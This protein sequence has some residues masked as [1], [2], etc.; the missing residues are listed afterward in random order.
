MWQTIAGP[1]SNPRQA[2]D[3]FFYCCLIR[4][5]KHNWSCGKKKKYDLEN[6]RRANHQFQKSFFK[7][8]SWFICKGNESSWKLDFKQINSFLIFIFA[9]AAAYQRKKYSAKNQVSITSCQSL[10]FSST[11]SFKI[12]KETYFG[13]P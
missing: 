2:I 1:Y 12:F 8:L 11:F 10:T 9:L 5:I 3:D 6:H 4:E 13:L 7:C